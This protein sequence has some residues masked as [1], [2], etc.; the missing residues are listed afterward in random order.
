MTSPQF[1][2]EWQG[3]PKITN[4][5][6]QMPKMLDICS[7]KRGS[8]S[9]QNASS[10]C[11]PPPYC[12]GSSGRKNPWLEASVVIRRQKKR[13][14]LKRPAME[15]PTSAQGANRISRRVLGL[16]E[17]L[18]GE[19][20]WAQ[21]ARESLE[22]GSSR[23]RDYTRSLYT[24]PQF[25]SDRTNVES[26]LQVARDIDPENIQ[27]AQRCKSSSGLS[28][29]H[30]FFRDV[31]QVKP[32]HCGCQIVVELS[33]I[34][35]TRNLTGDSIWEREKERSCDE[36]HSFWGTELPDGSIANLQKLSTSIS[37]R[38]FITRQCHPWRRKWL[39]SLDYG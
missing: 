24:I 9:V 30:F 10:V 5:R 26:I 35:N 32:L 25:L 11:N 19:A 21:E 38:R 33:Q 36:L 34:T 4:F 8:N 1:S 31:V 7:R 17:Q 18:V 27:V 28:R 22:I 12:C 29:F 39:L 20:L 14:R 6:S 15:K 37:N 13:R 2:V 3:I 23:R 16:W